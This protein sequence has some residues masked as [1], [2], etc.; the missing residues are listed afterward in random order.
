MDKFDYVAS[1]I[2]LRC[3]Q[4]PRYFQ[5][6]LRVVHVPGVDHLGAGFKSAVGEQGGVDIAAGDAEPG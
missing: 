5:S 1:G 4:T 3:S 6:A 2:D